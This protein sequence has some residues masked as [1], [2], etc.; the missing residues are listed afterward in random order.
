MDADRRVPNLSGLAW[1]RRPCHDAAG[2]HRVL[3]S[4]PGGATGYPQCFC[5]CWRT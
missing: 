5:C 1:R 4:G 2:C 3:L